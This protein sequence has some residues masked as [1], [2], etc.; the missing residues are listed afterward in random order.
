MSYPHKP[1]Q[2]HFDA[3]LGQH[4]VC[5]GPLLE[6]GHHPELGPG[7]M[8]SYEEEPGAPTSGVDC[9]FMPGD[10]TDVDEVVQRAEQWLRLRSDD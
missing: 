3:N 10:L 8:L 6:F 1:I 7:W 9:Y 4:S 2:V 5:D